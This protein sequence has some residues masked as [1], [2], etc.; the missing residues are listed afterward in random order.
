MSVQ[1][2]AK[3]MMKYQAGYYELEDK[4]LAEILAESNRRAF[5]AYS[6]GVWVTAFARRELEDGLRLIAPEDFIYSDTDS[7]KFLGNYDAAFKKFNQDQKRIAIDRGAYAKDSKGK[8]HYL[9]VYEFDGKY[10]K[11]CTL[12][13]KKYVYT[14]SSGLHCTIAG[15][16]KKKGAEELAKVGGIK[17]FKEGF[18]FHAAGGL[19]SIYNDFPEI[20]KWTVEGKEIEIIKNVYLKPSTYTLGLTGEYKRLIDD[21]QFWRYYNNELFE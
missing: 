17:A 21:L 18:V 15:V 8:N 11:F 2:P 6:W 4:P 16:N 9:G 10:D 14:D 12:G 5:Q 1:N 13:A 20:K 7:I 3:P 19:E